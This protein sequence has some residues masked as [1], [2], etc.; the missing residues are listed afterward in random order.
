MRAAQNNDPM[1]SRDRRGKFNPCPNVDIHPD[2]GEL[3][4]GYHRRASRAVFDICNEVGRI[5]Q[6]GHL[7]SSQT[8]I[9]ISFLKPGMYI[10]LILDGDVIRN[11]SFE[12]SH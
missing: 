7:L 11:H 5:L 3:I 4:V 1:S 6:T 12:V 9:D 8:R 2:R 10:L